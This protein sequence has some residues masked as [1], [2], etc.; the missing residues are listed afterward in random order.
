MRSNASIAT[1]LKDLRQRLVGED[2]DHADWKFDPNNY[3]M[4][5]VNARGRI[6]DWRPIDRRWVCVPKTATDAAPTCSSSS[7]ES[8]FPARLPDSLPAAQAIVV[9]S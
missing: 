6:G 1:L 9:L 8:Q 4:E 5:S 7:L 3:T 2:K